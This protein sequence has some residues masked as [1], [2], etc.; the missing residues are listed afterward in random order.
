MT[1][2]AH[3]YSHFPSR[4]EE[5]HQLDNLPLTYNDTHSLRHDASYGSQ[6]AG[7]ISYSAH[8]ITDYRDHHDAP[9][10]VE[11]TP[12]AQYPSGSSIQ[13]LHS[14]DVVLN[15]LRKRPAFS[16]RDWQW[17]FGASIFSFGCFAAVVGILA[18]NDNRS[19]ASWNFVFGVTLNTLIAVLSTLS[20][21]ALM[22]PVASCISQLKW[23]HLVGASRPLREVQVFDDASRGPWG[24][25]E[26]IWRLHIKTKLATWGSLITL[27]TL[28]MGPFAQQLLSYP[29]RSVNSGE[30]TF[31]TS[32]IYDSAYGE[33]RGLRAATGKIS[34][35]PREHSDTCL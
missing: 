5:Y 10:F 13:K 4:N 35:S 21:T 1:S 34:E 7:W 12:A 23:I 24:S 26:L 33:F 11:S 30:A 18:R 29:S 9:D 3:S 20:R 6:D 14:T 16:L 19:L 8:D 22:V 31:Y 25:L 15:P 32:H 27:L 2:M 28:A 17:E